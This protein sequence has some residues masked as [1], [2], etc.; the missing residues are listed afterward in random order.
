MSL[1]S[2]KEMRF[3]SKRREAAGVLV[4]FELRTLSKTAS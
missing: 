1:F 2:E 4:V 3:L